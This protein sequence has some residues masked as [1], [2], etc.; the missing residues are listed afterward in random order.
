MVSNRRNTELGLLV[1]VVVLIGA[2]YVLASLGSTEKI[3]LNIG[4]FLLMVMSLMLGAHLVVRRLAPD[5]DPILLP[6]AALL[7]GLGYVVIT[8]LNEKLA[9]LQATWTAVGVAAFIGVLLVVPR[10]RAIE[11]YRYTFAL[12]GIGLLLLPL[13]PHVGREIHGSRIWVAIGPVGFQPGELAKIAL[14]IFFASYLVEKRELLAMRSFRLGPLSLPDPKHLGP[15]LFAWLASIM[16]MVSQKDLGSSLLFFALFIVMLWVATSRPSYLAAGAVMFGVAAYGSWRT[17]GHV[18]SRVTTW[19][20]PWKDPLGDSFQI[21]KGWFAMANGGLTGTGLGLGNQEHIV[22]IESDFIFVAVAQELGL[23]GATLVLSAYLILVGSGLRIA[24]RSDHAFDKLLAV[25]L[26]TLI[27]VQAFIIIGG[28]VRVLPLTGVT[29]PFIA[30]GGSSLISSWIM[31][32][33]LLRLS[34][35]N[36]RRASEK[37]ALMATR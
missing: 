28:I 19:I 13:V 22:F 16:I 36:H 31:L 4:P 29:L 23:F 6:V 26:T 18:Q 27:G 15:V 1:M 14:A 21:V 20:N 30:Y 35:E 5:A 32:A 11:R 8:S 2:A 7:N 33:L 25:G 9:A 12:V 34:D 37:Q 24:A 17:F 10:T 3:P